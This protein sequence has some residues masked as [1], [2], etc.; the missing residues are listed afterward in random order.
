MATKRD[1]LAAEDVGWTEFLWLV[2]SLTAEQM[3]EP[4]YLAEGWSVKDLLGHIGAWQAETVQVLEQIRMG[5]YT[6]RWVD[7]DAFNQRFYQAN[8]DLPLPVVRA[9]CWSA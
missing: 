1:L 3:Q 7:V 4:G 2:E 6:P 8:R 5:T 9:E